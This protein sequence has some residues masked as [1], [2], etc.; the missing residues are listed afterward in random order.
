M[1]R[2]SRLF[3]SIVGVNGLKEVD[4]LLYYRTE[5][6]RCSAHMVR[7]SRLF[8]SIVGVNGLKEVDFLL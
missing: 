1:V 5:S 2:I 6:K 7:I 3:L 8:L 4:F